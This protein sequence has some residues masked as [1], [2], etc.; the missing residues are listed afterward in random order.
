MLRVVLSLPLSD[1]V[2]GLCCWE[3]CLHVKHLAQFQAFHG[4]GWKSFMFVTAHNYVFLPICLTCSFALV[5]LV[6]FFLSL[7]FFPLQ[8]FKTIIVCQFI[9]IVITFYMQVFMG[10][11]LCKSDFVSL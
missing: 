1:G 4:S 10:F 3:L 5:I 9:I 11:S 6:F 8:L 7:A 2:T